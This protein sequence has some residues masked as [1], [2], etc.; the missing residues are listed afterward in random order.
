MVPSSLIREDTPRNQRRIIVCVRKR[1][2]VPLETQAGGFDVVTTNREGGGQD[3]G[4]VVHELKHAVDMSEFVQQVKAKLC[5]NSY[6]LL[7]CSTIS[8]TVQW[9]LKLQCLYR[10][11]SGSIRSLMKMLIIRTCTVGL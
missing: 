11:F 8:E 3:G 2:M 4:L 1:P 7:N 9:K 6:V 10:M 5:L